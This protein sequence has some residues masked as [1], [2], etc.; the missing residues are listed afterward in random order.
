MVSL[1]PWILIK[2]DIYWSWIISTISIHCHSNPVFVT[3]RVNHMILWMDIYDGQTY[4]LKTMG[5]IWKNM[6]VVT[7]EYGIFTH[8][9]HL[10]IWLFRFITG[11]TF[12]WDCVLW[13]IVIIMVWIILWNKLRIYR[14]PPD[15]FKCSCWGFVSLWQSFMMIWMLLS[16]KYYSVSHRK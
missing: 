10:K 11:I 4:G 12:R 6:D 15:P 7:V 1:W 13:H 2:R 9:F 16:N 14:V 5:G 3:P 8:T